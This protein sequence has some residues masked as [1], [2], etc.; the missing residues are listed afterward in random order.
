MFNIMISNPLPPTVTVIVDALVS[1][2]QSAGLQKIET[3]LLS[4]KKHV[5]FGLKSY[6]VCILWKSKIN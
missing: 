3:H 6:L 4:G 1:Q 2:F 5:A